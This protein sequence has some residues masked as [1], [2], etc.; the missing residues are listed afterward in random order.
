MLRYLTAGESH[1]QC[2]TTII[3]GIP[4][5]LKLS[6]EA[7]NAQLERRQRGYGRGK[8]CSLS[9]TGL[10]LQVE[11]AEALHLEVPSA[12]RYKTKIGITGVI[13]WLPALRPI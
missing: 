8:E 11:C 10:G 2:L 4:A 6:A 13:T 1:G 12:W 3:E 9:G 5:G 7:V